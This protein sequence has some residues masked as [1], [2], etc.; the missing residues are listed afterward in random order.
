M[1]LNLGQLLI[2]VGVDAGRRVGVSCGVFC[3]ICVGFG[4]CGFGNHVGGEVVGVSSDVWGGIV[5]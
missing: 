4:M 3:G 5:D 1:T 2:V